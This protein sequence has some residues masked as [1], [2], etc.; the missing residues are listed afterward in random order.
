[1][2]RPSREDQVGRIDPQFLVLEN[3]FQQRRMQ[4]NSD[5]SGVEPEMV[6]VF[7][8]RGPVDNFLIALRN[9]PELE[10]LG[11]IEQE[12]QPDNLFFYQDDATREIRGK[13]FFVMS[14]F[15][16]LQQLKSLWDNYYRANQRFERGTTKWRDLF[17]L[18]HDVRFWNV[19]DRLQETGIINDLRA[20][21]AQQEE[22]INF[23]IELW[24]RSTSAKRTEAKNRVL[25]L[26]EEFEG[27]L[28]KECTI[29]DISYHAL[30]VRAS[31]RVFD[32]L[33]ED[34]SIELFKAYDVMYI[35][36][37]GQC[38][39]EVLPIDEVEEMNAA[40]TATTLTAPIVALLDGLPLQNHSVLA[41]RLTIDDPDNFEADYP[42][43]NRTHGTAMASLIVRG[44]LDSADR[45][46]KSRL[47]VRPI[48]K[49][50]ED[51][52][53]TFE[54]IPENVLTLDIIHRAV[55]RMFEAADGATAESVKVI[56]LSIG[57]P[58]RIYDNSIS[59]LAR[60]IDWLS[61]KYNVLFVISAGNC[62]DALAIPNL[63]TVISQPDDLAKHSIRFI[64]DNIR[65]RKI[66]SPA[67]AIN[68]LTIG[69]AHGALAAGVQLNRR[70]SIYEQADFPSPVSRIGF[71]HRRSIKPDVLMPGGRVLFNEPLTVQELAINHS[72]LAPGQ[73]VAR[74]SRTGSILGTGYTRGTSN[75]AALTSRAA[76]FLHESFL[77]IENI[78]PDLL[79]NYFPVMA[80]CLLAHCA[81]WK[82]DTVSSLL[83]SIPNRT[84][85]DKDTIS[86]F[87]GYGQMDLTRIFE[88]TQQRVT[89]IG[90]G[91]LHSEEGH[92]YKLPLPV[93]ISGPVMWR[94]LTVT[95]AW[96]SPVNPLNQVYRKA[97]LWYDFPDDNVDSIL[98]VNR[99]FYDNHTVM[100]GTLHHE[101]FDGS[102]ASAFVDGTDLNIRVNC[103]QD[104]SPFDE[105]IKYGFAVTL[106]VLPVTNLDLYTEIRAKVQPQ[107]QV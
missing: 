10:W 88:C 34:T 82:D 65:H 8:T 57:D 52:S 4:L 90:Y 80:K 71:G 99:K 50:Y 1:M 31:V 42:A 15:R 84:G 91:A 29:E 12:Y 24:F 95:L 22:H 72:I 58:S 87:L 27:E 6:L 19:S 102:R 68:A 51:F 76:G 63:Q 33:A 62:F 2:R 101:I 79:T 49:S 69:A 39:V 74:P 78:S 106:E 11:D 16:G 96:F 64:Y 21:I 66:I 37:V 60:L 44:D 89:L 43:N 70:I 93:S 75:A 28:I 105:S 97:K 32:N 86:R 48:M 26:V 47:Y 92:L 7:E 107:V 23:E 103:K 56:N 55:R 30:L 17:D 104:A 45:H 3:A 25:A 53:R 67:E 98:N 35:R 40:P 77:E 54:K 20:R 41:N 81:T 83:N 100:R 13:V 61:Y 14:N 18:L 36:P 73:K 85:N 46:L 38:A 9:F 5:S 59:S 94:Q